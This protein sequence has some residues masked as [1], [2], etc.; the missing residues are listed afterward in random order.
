MA[1][2]VVRAATP[3]GA[4]TVAFLTWLLGPSASGDVGGAA[5]WYRVSY[6]T[7]GRVRV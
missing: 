2:L 3:D 6:R 1:N 7:P 4:A 5:V